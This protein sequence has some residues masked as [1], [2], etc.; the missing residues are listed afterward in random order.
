M[1]EKD[2][3]PFFHEAQ[4]RHH[5]FGWVMPIPEVA[6]NPQLAAREWWADYPVGDG[7]VAGPGAPYQLVDT[8]ASIGGDPSEP[9]PASAQEILDEIGWAD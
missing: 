9:T 8:P 1:A 4:R 3:E 7:S 5:P 6:A 2:V